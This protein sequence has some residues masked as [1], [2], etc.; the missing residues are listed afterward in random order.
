[1]KLVFAI[2]NNDDGPIVVAE[3]IKK[4]YHVTKIAS[5]G[6]F[7]K[8]GNH[9]FITA[10]ENEQVDDVIETIKKYSKKRKYTAPVDA[11]T[12]AAI[13]G[14]LTP[15]EITI[16]GATVFVTNIEHFERV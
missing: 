8:K 16:G 13:G 10:V 9:T 5:T 12:A 7:L 11:V 3:L 14:G 15:I 2:V 4:G 1:M 6:G